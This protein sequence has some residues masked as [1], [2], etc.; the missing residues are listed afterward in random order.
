VSDRCLWL[1]NRQKG[2]SYMRHFDIYA[3]CSYTEGYPL[4]FIEAAAARLPVV[5]S[6]IPV[7]KTI[8]PA[9]CAKFFRLD[10]TRSL[11]KA[12]SEASSEAPSLSEN[13]Y[14]YY[15]NN[16]TSK[17]MYESYISLYLAS[18]NESPC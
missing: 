13:I 10:D 8:I 3:L 17:K 7:F 1:G 12:L 6:D 2:Y 18:K 14:S 4:S 15:M 9:G 16:L 11:C 5:A